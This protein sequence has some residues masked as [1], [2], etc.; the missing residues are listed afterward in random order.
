MHQQSLSGGFADAPIDAARAFRAIMNA[1]ARPGTDQPIA[2]AEAPAPM[3]AAAATTLMT[4]CDPETPIHLAGAYDVPAIRDWIAFHIGAPLT[5]AGDCAFALG[6]WDDLL[7]LD[8]FAIGTAEYP[9]RSA[10]LLVDQGPEATVQAQLS[11]PG[12]KSTQQ[13]TLPQ[14]E[15]F[16]ANSSLFPLGL[17]F[18]FTQDNRVTALPRST[19]V[20]A[21]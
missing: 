5:G 18:I 7:P 9:D 19:R 12:I 16:Q 8:R 2:G 11:G 17:D 6:A 15:P 10:T 3:S 21:L 20:E 1:M 14:I 4:L 13:A